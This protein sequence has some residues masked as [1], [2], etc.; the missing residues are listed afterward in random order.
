MQLEKIQEYDMKL[1]ESQL[2][3]LSASGWAI[4]AI[5]ALQTDCRVHAGLQA[6]FNISRHISPV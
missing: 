3:G 1:P 5:M 6:F 4:K 2:S